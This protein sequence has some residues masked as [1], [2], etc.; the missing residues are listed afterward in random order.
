MEKIHHIARDKLELASD[1]QKEYY[2]RKAS[3]CPYNVG[4]IVWFHD[5]PF[6]RG[7]SK[8]LQRPWRGPFKITAR[9]CDLVYRIQETQRSKPRV[10]HYNRLKPFV[11]QTP[12]GLEWDVKQL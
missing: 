1:K 2:D 7:K 5:K 4:D 9:L 8:K 11:G 6:M 12:K 10:V 3:L